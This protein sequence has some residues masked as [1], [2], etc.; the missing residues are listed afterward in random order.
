MIHVRSFPEDD[1]EGA[2]NREFGSVEILL[3]RHLSG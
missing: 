1:P 3:V 2:L